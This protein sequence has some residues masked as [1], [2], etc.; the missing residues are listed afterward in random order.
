MS[1]IQLVKF[2]TIETD[3]YKMPP[4]FFRSRASLQY[5]HGF[6]WYYVVRNTRYTPSSRI[7][8]SSMG[9]IKQ[10]GDYVGD[11]VEDDYTPT[12][13]L[14]A[15]TFQKLDPNQDMTMFDPTHPTSQ[16][17]TFTKTTLRSIA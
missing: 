16:F 9:V 5:S 15:G 10:S 13:S 2:Q 17:E 1:L 8:A 3:I 4:C 11:G 14:E 12:I 6:I 7:S